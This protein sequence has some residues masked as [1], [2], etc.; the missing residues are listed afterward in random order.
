[1]PADLLAFAHFD[2]AAG[3]GTE[4]VPGKGSASEGKNAA[5][6][7]RKRLSGVEV[8]PETTYPSVRVLEGETD[9]SREVEIE[10]SRPAMTRDSSSASCGPPERQGE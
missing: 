1:M 7:D 4:L 6:S 10:F 2:L 5:D 9:T 8:R 3:F